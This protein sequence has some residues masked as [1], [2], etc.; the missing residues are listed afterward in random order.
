M[1]ALLITLGS[2][3]VAKAASRGLDIAAYL[4]VV[5]ALGYWLVRQRVGRAAT[6][7]DAGGGTPDIWTVPDRRAAWIGFAGACLLLPDIL[8]AGAVHSSAGPGFLALLESRP[9]PDVAAL[10]LMPFLAFAFGRA[11]RGRRGAWNAAL[12]LGA[13]LVARPA[14]AGHWRALV[15]PLHEAA[16]ALWLGTLLVLAVAA[17]PEFEGD[18]A[19]P[20][21]RAAAVAGLVRRF[22]PLALFAAALVGLSGVATAWLHLKYFA[23]LWATGYGRLL[24]V[25]LAFVAAVAGLGA[26]NWRRVLPDLGTPP[27]TARLRRS[28]AGELALAAVVFVLSAVLSSMPGPKVPR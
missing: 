13:A 2:A 14:L 21:Q 16:G 1:N 28:A 5:G 3:L 15:N 11:A 18:A 25:K 27:A 6:A 9:A 23:A 26:W 17:L 8:W 7:A 19:T 4:G 22:S 12:I 10:V 20:A 24:L